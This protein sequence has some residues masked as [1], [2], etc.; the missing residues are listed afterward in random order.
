MKKIIHLVCFLNF[1]AV[2][3]FAQKKDIEFTKDNFPNQKEQLKEAK[4]AIKQGDEYYKKSE[5][6]FKNALPYYLKAYEFN[7]NNAELNF[8]IGNCLLHSADKSHAYEYLEKA[9]E[10][11]PSVHPE[12][13]YQLGV[14]YQLNDLFEKAIQQFNLYKQEYGKK[15]TEADLAKVNKH[16]SECNT[17]IELLK[18]P[19]RVF[20]DLLP[21]TVNSEDP[22]YVP[23]I[24]ADESLL[25]FTSRRKGTTGDCFDEFI[26]EPCEDIYYS[27]KENGKWTPAKN[28]GPPINTDK[29]DASICLSPDGTD[30]YLYRD[31]NGDGNIYVSHLIGNTWTKPEKLP[32]P[33]NSKAH[34]PSVAVSYDGK[35]IYFVS[36]REGGL[37]GHDIY[38]CTKDAK[39]K[40]GKAI[41]LG[42]TVNTQYDEDGIFMMPDGKTLYFSSKGHNTMGGYDVFKTTNVNG[43][44][45]TPENIGY[46]VNDADD[47]VFFVLSAS[48][49]RGY[50]SA[51]HKG[52]IGE[53]DIYII[54]FLGPEK[55][56]LL[57]TEDNLLA[58]ATAPIKETKVQQAVEI[59]SP[60]LT[61]LKGVITD[62]F[63]N[64]PLEAS[65]DLIDNVKNEVLAT[66]KSNSA[67]GKYLVSLPSGRNYGIAVRAE[68][69][70]FHSENF[71]IPASAE[72]QEVIKNIALKSISVGNKIVLRNIFFDFNKATLRP[73][74]TAELERLI[75]L[76]NEFPN[77]RIEISGH[78]DNVGSAEYNQKL[79]E[80]RARAVVE[81]LVSKGIVSSRLEYKGYGFTQPIASNETEQGRQENRRT[82][83]KILSK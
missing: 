78:T 53:K 31:D 71:D 7:P 11:N 80:N 60:Q 66:F 52:G 77:M 65:I 23:V 22:D 15:F 33:I 14:A 67:T 74:S 29:H 6:L 18:N 64:K 27:I 9:L 37:G 2:L 16:I 44:W 82:E 63:T 13:R 40:W 1:Y 26:N 28:I 55:Q 73:E 10:L 25:I 62:A 32:E 68:G 19:Q 50:Y 81:Y 79:S 41:N 34:E 70:L 54:T 57:T 8:K 3:L 47:D 39:G 24:S 17:G 36:N 4:E 35:T 12:L 20:I 45:T 46:P 59:K 75:S 5:A 51:A 69:Y 76:L 42:P 49:R 38:Y 83:F 61:I 72:Y 30:I 56:P 21:S 48:G 58:S 43:V